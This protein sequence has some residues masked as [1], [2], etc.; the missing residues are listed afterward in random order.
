[1]AKTFY[2][3]LGVARDASQDEIKKAYRR[4][5]SKYHPDKTEEIDAEDRIKEINEAYKVLK[6]KDQR[7]V[8]DRYGSV[9]PR[10]SGGAAPGWGVGNADLA[11]ILRQMY[12]MGGM[13]GHPGGI[14]IQ[15]VTVPVDVMIHG[16]NTVITYVRSHEVNRGMI[17]MRQY[18]APITLEP[19]T[20]VGTELEIPE[21]PGVQ[22]RIIPNSGN[23]KCIVQGL[24]LVVPLDVD[25]FLVSIGEKAK[26][27]HPNGKKYEITVPDGSENGTA[28]R[29]PKM[30]LSH[31]NGAQ[32]SLI[33][34]VNFILPSLTEEQK[35]SIKKILKGS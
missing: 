35:E 17:S 1:M 31:I 10:P 12:E 2:D 9:G 14:T 15:E 18:R 30:G 22:F 32:G 29:L 26:V 33:A 21:A 3:V 34:V 24:D 4:L 6:D 19:N 5:A 23:K 28:L 8:Y 13:D 20:K 11:D 16:G 27:T 25:P 7:A